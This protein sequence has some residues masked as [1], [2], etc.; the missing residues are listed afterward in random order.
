MISWD[1]FSDSVTAVISVILII[2]S[3]LK[4]MQDPKYQKAKKTYRII[5]ILLLT[6]LL[7]KVIIF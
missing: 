1:G 3:Y 4:K 5:G 6:A 7:I 2:L